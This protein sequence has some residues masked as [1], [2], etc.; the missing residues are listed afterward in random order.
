MRKIIAVF[1]LSLLLASCSSGDSISETKAMAIESQDISANINESTTVISTSYE[2]SN[3]GYTPILTNQINNYNVNVD[4]EIVSLTEKA[5][6]IYYV[7]FLNLSESTFENKGT[8]LI[9]I[10]DDVWTSNYSEEFIRTGISYDSF[11][12]FLCQTFSENYVNNVLFKRNV[13]HNFNNELCF[14]PFAAYIPNNCFDSIEFYTSE[15]TDNKI[16]LNAVAKYVDIEDPDSTWE[17]TYQFNIIKTDN[18]WRF[19]NFEEWK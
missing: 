12:N 8:V 13:Y 10:S 15:V 16:T 7:Y 11:Y 14:T 1:V 3:F 6:D 9:N 5:T 18:G 2:L 19:D 4:N 17:S